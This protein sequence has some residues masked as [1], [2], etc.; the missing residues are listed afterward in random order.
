[1]K[2]PRKRLF[3]FVIGVVFAVLASILGFGHQFSPSW[4]QTPALDAIEFITPDDA[5]PEPIPERGSTAGCSCLGCGARVVGLRPSTDLGLTINAHPTF[6]ASVSSVDRQQLQRRQ[7]N[8]SETLLIELFIMDENDRELALVE[9]SSIE[10]SG[11][12]AV[13]LPESF[14]GLEIGKN[15]HW[16]ITVICN[17]DDF[18]DNLYT[19]G[20]VKRIEPNAEI[21]NAIG[22]TS[23]VEKLAIYATEGIWHETLTALVELL[24]AEPNN[25]SVWKAWQ[26]V[27]AVAE[28]ESIAEEPVIKPTLIELE[29]KKRSLF[30]K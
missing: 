3:G 18:S 16:Y 10:L 22:S 8:S 24:E 2:I 19:E 17:L 20:W 4:A 25:P 14:P 26:R 1:M 15:Y 7:P 29:P 21:Q 30:K 6:F 9:F 5:A 11:T 23:W 27:L 12:M 28:L 13:T